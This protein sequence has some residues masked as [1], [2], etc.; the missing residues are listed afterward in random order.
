MTEEQEHG[1]YQNDKPMVVMNG[2]EMMPFNRAGQVQ[3]AKPLTK[4]ELIQHR[5]VIQSVMKAVMKEDVHY[6]SV[7][8]NGKPF[9]T[10]AGAEVLLTTFKIGV[11]P[12]IHDV[13]HVGTAA[14]RVE[15]H[16][17]CLVTGKLLG[18]G[19]G[20]CTSDETKYKWRNAICLEEYHAYPETQRQEKW[21]RL[22]SGEVDT[23]YQVR[24]ECEDVR[25]TVLK[26]AKKRAISDG[27]L[28][29]LGASDCFSQDEDCI[30]GDD[31][32]NFEANVQE[33]KQ[34]A[35]QSGNMTISDGKGKRLFAILRE[36]GKE[37]DEF[38]SYYKNKYGMD[39]KSTKDVHPN[40]YEEVCEWAAGAKV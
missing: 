9:L 1:G 6:T 37:L 11:F 28:T 16:L 30:P 24:A 12:V 3:E 29:C 5:A 19:V 32:V 2:Q 23:L 36:S 4:E 17:K 26:M 22:K 27:V 34:K 13:S 33:P 39:V 18:I 31:G 10:K 8:S 14:Y 35:S 25:N 20:E 38:K 15:A 40:H 21:K 7:V